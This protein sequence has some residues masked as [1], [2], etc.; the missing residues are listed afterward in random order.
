MRVRAY[1]A[2]L[3]TLNCKPRAC[4]LGASGAWP[5]AQRACPYSVQRTDEAAIAPLRRHSPAARMRLPLIRFIKETPNLNLSQ[6]VPYDWLHPLGCKPIKTQHRLPLGPPGE[7]FRRSPGACRR[8]QAL[9]NVP[10][11]SQ[12]LPTRSPAH[13]E[14]PWRLCDALH[15]TPK[16]AQALPDALQRSHDAFK[17]SEAPPTRSPGGPKGS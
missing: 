1:L 2:E 6:W 14:A 10:R 8:S 16:C 4:N 7:G 9:R 11:R 15:G 12:G 17:R 13:P 5:S 3:H